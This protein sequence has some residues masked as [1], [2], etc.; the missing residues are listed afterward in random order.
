MT[1]IWWA[2]NQILQSF[3]WKFWNRRNYS[4]NAFVLFVLLCLIVILTE[5]YFIYSKKNPIS[6]P[7]CF[8]FVNLLNNCFNQFLLITFEIIELINQSNFLHIDKFKWNDSFFLSNFL[9]SK[10]SFYICILL[11]HVIQLRHR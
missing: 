9:I 4:M 10:R 8:F 3:L 1:S 7:L 11:R 6:V 5:T 2:K